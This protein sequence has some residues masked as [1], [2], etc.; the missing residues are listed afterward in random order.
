M[1]RGIDAT[2]TDRSIRADRLRAPAWPDEVAR[3]RRATD[4]TTTTPK[5]DDTRD[6][7][8]IHSATV[9]LHPTDLSLLRESGLPIEPTGEARNRVVP[10]GR[11]DLAC[12]LQAARANTDDPTHRAVF[13]SFLKQLRA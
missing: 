7:M 2:P 9:E 11:A 13:L 8:I 5:N 4:K 10:I 1:S 12:A 6:P 3:A